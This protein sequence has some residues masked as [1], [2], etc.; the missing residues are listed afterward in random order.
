MRP[1]AACRSANLNMRGAES[2]LSRA[3]LQCGLT[4]AVTVA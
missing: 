1:Y 4:D 2:G 3:E